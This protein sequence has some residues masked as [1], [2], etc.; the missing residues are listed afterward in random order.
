M[1]ATW[2][3]WY[4]VLVGFPAGCLACWRWAREYG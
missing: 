3:L 4:L 2:L 1:L